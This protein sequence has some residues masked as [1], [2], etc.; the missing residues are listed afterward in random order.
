[1]VTLRHGKNYKQPVKNSRDRSLDSMEYNL[2]L[3]EVL[4]NIL[5]HQKNHSCLQKSVNEPSHWVPGI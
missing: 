2:P 3:F 4:G 1:M 5:S